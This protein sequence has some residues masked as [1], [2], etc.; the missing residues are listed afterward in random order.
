MRVFPVKHIGIMVRRWQSDGFDIL[1][2]S[3]YMLDFPLDVVIDSHQVDGL[4]DPS[5]WITEETAHFP[6]LTTVPH[7]APYSS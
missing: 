1:K 5:V 4:P 7:K 2:E 6:D 3:G